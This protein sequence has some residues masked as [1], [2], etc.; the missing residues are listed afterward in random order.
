MQPSLWSHGARQVLLR[1]RQGA[2]EGLIHIDFRPKDSKIGGELHGVGLFGR[3]ICSSRSLQ[4]EFSASRAS[5]ALCLLPALGL[6][7]QDLSFLAY[8]S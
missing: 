5:Q 2:S 3:N 8:G 4:P 1:H 7:R 6:R